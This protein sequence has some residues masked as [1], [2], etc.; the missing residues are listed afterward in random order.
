VSKIERWLKRAEAFGKE[1]GY[2]IFVH[3]SVYTFLMENGEERLKMLESVTKLTIDFV[4]D[5]KISI[6]EFY[7]FSTAR[8]T[9]VTAEYSITP[10]THA[11]LEGTPVTPRMKRSFKPP[12][13]AEEK[14]K[15]FGRKLKPRVR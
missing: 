12:K 10:P 9:D 11:R 2:T 6:S 15:A 7:C 13:E 3:P 5:S 14:E 1:T 8:N 4:V